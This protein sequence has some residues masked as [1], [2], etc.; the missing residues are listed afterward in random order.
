[1]D[2]ADERFSIFSVLFNGELLD[3]WKVTNIAHE[4]Q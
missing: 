3:D 1:M 2:A 4:A